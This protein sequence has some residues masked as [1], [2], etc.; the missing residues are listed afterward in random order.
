MGMGVIH[1]QQ[2][3][4][5]CGFEKI[6]PLRGPLRFRIKF[7][8]ICILANGS[9]LSDPPSDPNMDPAYLGVLVMVGT[10]KKKFKPTVTAIMERY[11]AKYRGKG[12]LEEGEVAQGTSGTSEEAG[13]SS[14][15]APVPVAAV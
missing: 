8:K 11:Y 3:G 15:P 12:G 2:A 4:S 5:H 14:A 6:S 13:P 1:S 9:A 7:F 10:N